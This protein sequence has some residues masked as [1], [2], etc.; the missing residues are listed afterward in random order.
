MKRTNYSITSMLVFAVTAA[1][2]LIAAP[3]R[4]ADE[5]KAVV[6]TVL[7]V[8]NAESMSYD[9]TVGT[10][11]LK[12]TGSVVTWFTDRP[13]RVAGHIVTPSFVKIWSEGSDSFKSDPPNASLSIIDDGKVSNAVVELS[14]PTLKGK[15][16]SYQVKIL[17]GDLPASGGT[18]SLFIEGILAPAYTPGGGAVIGGVTGALIGAISGNAGRGAAI[19]AGVGILRGA[20]QHSKTEN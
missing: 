12:N 9:K 2:F 4:A 16:I 8:Q 15:D 10:L 7:F 5:K 14:N 18:F 17:E 3:V 1:S 20:I 13:A 19:G 11:T 6:P